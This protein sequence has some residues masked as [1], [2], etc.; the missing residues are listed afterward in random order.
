MW[1]SGMIEVVSVTVGVIVFALVTEDWSLVASLA[2]RR[3]FNR[4]CKN[5][6]PSI[7]IHHAESKPNLTNKTYGEKRFEWNFN[8]WERNYGLHFDMGLF[9]WV[10]CVKMI[11]SMTRGSSIWVYKGDNRAQTRLVNKF[12][13][14][15]IDWFRQRWGKIFVLCDF[16]PKN[17]PLASE[18]VKIIFY[19]F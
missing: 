9:S 14:H 12:H 3:L 1:V 8:E 5:M 15:Q 17:L 19:F 13:H 4:D 2:A 18:L 11:V 16:L 6:T 7:R 10:V